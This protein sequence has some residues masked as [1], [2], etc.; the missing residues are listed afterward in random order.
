MTT[1]SATYGHALPGLCTVGLVFSWSEE[2]LDA[3]LQL[4]LILIRSHV[5]IAHMQV[6]MARM[7]Q[8]HAAPYSVAY[9]PDLGE[10]RLGRG[11]SNLTKCLLGLQMGRA[12]RAAGRRGPGACATTSTCPRA[13][14]P[15]TRSD[16]CS[17]PCACKPGGSLTLRLS[18]ASYVTG[19]CG[20]EGVSAHSK[21]AHVPSG[22][23]GTKWPVVQANR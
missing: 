23:P 11:Y 1:A 16:P 8:Y 15:G 17:P 13:S 5:R 7:E 4:A 6:C 14:G 9:S 22:P 21:D 10:T 3:Q 19:S 20:A 18:R 12:S 2:G